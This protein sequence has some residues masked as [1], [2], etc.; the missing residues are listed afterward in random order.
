MRTQTTRLAALLA[1]AALAAGS[2]LMLPARASA[3]ECLIGE[4]RM[5][6]GNFEPRNWAY[7][8][9]QLLP[10]SQNTA[11]FSILGTT[12]GGDGQTN[13][14]LPN[15]SGRFPLGAGQGPGLSY[16]VLGEA[17]GAESVTLTTSQMPAHTHQ[18]AAVGTA[19]NASSPQSALPAAGRNFYATG[20][21]NAALNAQAAGV[22]GGSQPHSVMPPYLG[23]NYIICLYGIFPQR[24]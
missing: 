3:Q 18:L 12:Y 5:F 9:G 20:A 15:L 22:T 23:I 4:V 11:L 24:N 2:M 19:G 6:A 13:F 7:C 17:G 14:A 21:A 16:R 8:N 1:V 10:I